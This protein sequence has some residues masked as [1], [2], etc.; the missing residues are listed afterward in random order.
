MAKRKKQVHIYL[1]NNA[2]SYLALPCQQD[3]TRIT[4]KDIWAIKNSEFLP[5]LSDLNYG[6][7]CGLIVSDQQKGQRLFE[8]MTGLSYP[9]LYDRRSLFAYDIDCATKG[10]RE[11]T[12]FMLPS[13]KKN[14][15]ILSI[16][17]NGHRDLTRNMPAFKRIAESTKAIKGEIERLF[18]DEVNTLRDVLK[19]AGE[20]RTQLGHPT[21][22]AFLKHRMVPQLL[23]KRV[24][25]FLANN[26]V[27]NSAA[28]GQLIVKRP[29]RSKVVVPLIFCEL[30]MVYDC[31]I[32]GR[33][34]TGND[35]F[36]AAHYAMSGYCHLF[37]T[38][39]K[40]LQRVLSGMDNLPNK[41][42]N[43]ES[44]L[45]QHIRNR[46]STPMS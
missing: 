7:A 41:V 39:D 12:Y 35:A 26:G 15:A 29:H 36:D 20:T 22:S 42:M 8:I 28:V 31:L 1:D 3:R 18:Q 2:W 38:K 34:P 37:I 6:E 24:A 14:S 23:E 43:V 4:R 10:K 45:E 27:P 44:F 40:R 16:M 30:A 13:T 9:R 19:D 17:K 5:I 21:V 32:E 33:T 46:S 11:G 25:L